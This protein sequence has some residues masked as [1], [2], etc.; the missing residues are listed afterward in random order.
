MLALF[1]G[2]LGYHTFEHFKDKDCGLVADFS[3]EEESDD[4][5][6]NLELQNFIGTQSSF[7]FFLTL[8]LGSKSLN[9]FDKPSAWPSEVYLQTQ[10]SP[11]EING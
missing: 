4:S 2:Q 10:H 11:P 8:Q 6:V 3:D 9:P 5:E 7:D 1:I